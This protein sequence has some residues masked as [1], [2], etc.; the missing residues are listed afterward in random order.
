MTMQSAWGTSL[1]DL[2]N[3]SWAED[4]MD[5][6]AEHGQIAVRRARFQRLCRP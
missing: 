1:G 2:G 6:E 5:E 3:K 4:A